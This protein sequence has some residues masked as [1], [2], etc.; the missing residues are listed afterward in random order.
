MPD[1]QA[2]VYE[3]WIQHYLPRVAGD[4]TRAEEAADAARQALERGESAPAAD[5]AG[6]RAVGLVKPWWRPPV[7]FWIGLGGF[8]VLNVAWILLNRATCA[9]G[10]SLANPLI[11]AFVQVCPSPASVP[12]PKSTAAAGP[13]YPWV[14]FVANIA[15]PIALVFTRYRA[16]AVGILVG[17]AIALALFIVVAILLAAS[18]F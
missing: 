5:Q 16:A 2:S 13:T 9:A 15:A 11:G 18:G 4:R 1:D 14:Q 6:L 12:V 7:A 17:F 8:I 10:D 3:A